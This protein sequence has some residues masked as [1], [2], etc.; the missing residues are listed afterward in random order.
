MS[1]EEPDIDVLIQ[2]KELTERQHKALYALYIGSQLAEK[3]ALTTSEL[4]KY[5][6]MFKDVRLLEN[7][8]DT[9]ALLSTFREKGWVE[10][11]G[12]DTDG[13]YKN[14]ISDDGWDILEPAGIPAEVAEAVEN[15]E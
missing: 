14:K 6:S 5:G 11:V 8:A 2:V 1:E 13:N 15:N 9:A 3:V 12:K 10:V 7:K 4:Y